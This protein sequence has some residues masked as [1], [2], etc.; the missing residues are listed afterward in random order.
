MYVKVSLYLLL[1]LGSSL[2]GFAQSFDIE[3]GR[4]PMSTLDGPWRFHTGDDASWA[5]AELDDSS[6]SSISPDRSYDDQGFRGYSGVSWYR[7]KVD[8]P[9]WPTPIGLYFPYVGDSFQVF[10][11]GKLIGQMGGL[12]PHPDVVF[13]SKALFAVPQEIGR[14]GVPLQIAVRVWRW[15]RMASYTEGGIC[16]T[17]R[18]GSLTTLAEWQKLQQHEGYWARTDGVMSFLANL[19]TALAGLAL[20]VLRPREREYLWFGAAQIFWSLQAMIHILMMTEHVRFIPSEI[21]MVAAT[22]AAM[23]LN[24]EFFVTLMGQRKRIRYWTAVASVAVYIFLLL[25]I[26]HGWMTDTRY[27]AGET[28]FE[29]LYGVCVTALIYGGAKSGNTEAKLL[30]VP[31][32]LSFL[33]NFISPLVEIPALARYTW[34]QAFSARFSELFSW[35]FPMRAVLL[36]GNLAMFSVVAVLVLRFARSRKDE[37]R[38]EA[39]LAAARAVQQVLVPENIPT[40]QGFQIECVYKP[41]GEVGGDFFQILPLGEGDALV[42][43]GDVS[44]K[45]M[46]AAMTVSLLVG[47]VRA[48]VRNTQSPA[49]ILGAINQNMIGRTSGG[50]TTCLILHVRRNGAVTAANAGH[51]QPYLNGREIQVA[52]GL[53]LGLDTKAVYQETKFELAPAEQVTLLTDGVVEAR[54]ANGELFGFERTASMS[55]HP[56]AEIAAAAQKFGQEDDITVLSLTRE[57]DREDLNLLEPPTWSA[58]PA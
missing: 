54:T 58:A 43:I 11:G 37:E 35:P 42:A 50:F 29:L 3:K 38:L 39:E 51:V 36:A 56:A 23:L 28:V 20:F 19:L 5:D 12:P 17:P 24:L 49:E 31:F 45:G 52:T 55:A 14:A 53:P 10:A 15:D 25:P 18:I 4:V 16:A 48:L 7:L 22:S 57:P 47:L 1:I 21:L 32:T 26:S 40:V 30:L 8:V 46:P 33:C 27:V 6:W 41:A 34:V 9:D 2:S 44:G 13:A